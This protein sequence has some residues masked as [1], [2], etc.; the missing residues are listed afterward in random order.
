M[1]QPELLDV[2]GQPM[3]LG[4]TYY[5]FYKLYPISR[6]DHRIRINAYLSIIE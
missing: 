6:A 1:T 4:M 2:S 3:S 5:K